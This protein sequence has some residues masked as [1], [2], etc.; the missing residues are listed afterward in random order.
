MIYWLSINKR[1]A[2]GWLQCASK[3]PPPTPARRLLR[4]AFW[5]GWRTILR[6]CCGCCRHGYLGLS[7]L[8]KDVQFRDLLL[9]MFVLLASILLLYTDEVM[10]LRTF[11]T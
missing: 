6:W 10:E 2:K 1:A 7:P 11:L 8:Q 9:V 5:L 3:W 4:R